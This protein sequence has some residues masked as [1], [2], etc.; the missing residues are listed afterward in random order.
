[1]TPTDSN[2]A[3]RSGGARSSPH[4]ILEEE[5]EE[6]RFE[7]GDMV[8]VNTGIAEDLSDDIMEEAV[9]VG[10]QHRS[11]SN[12]KDC[13]YLHR[14][15]PLQ[16]PRNY[17]DLNA[18]VKH[19]TTSHGKQGSNLAQCRYLASVLEEGKWWI[20]LDCG[21]HRRCS[22]LKCSLS[23]SAKGKNCKVEPEVI[24]GQVAP[25]LYNIANKNK[26]LPFV[27]VP[28]EV[29]DPLTI[30]R[31]DSRGNPD[32]YYQPFSEG[33]K[34]G[35]DYLQAIMK[36]PTRTV[37]KLNKEIAIK[38]LKI[39]TCLLE[40]VNTAVKEKNEEKER[41]FRILQ[42][43]LPKMLLARIAK[44]KHLSA[45]QRRRSAKKLQTQVI[46]DRI[47]KFNSG[48][49]GQK[50][51]FRE[52]CNPLSLAPPSGKPTDN[53]VRAMQYLKVGR[54]REAISALGSIGV[55][56]LTPEVLEALKNMHPSAT[57]VFD[58]PGQEEDGNFVVAPGNSS[59][60]Q[61]VKLDLNN[62][63]YL[64]QQL[65]SFPR[66]SAA[67]KDGFYPQFYR[68]MLKYALPTSEER[69]LTAS[70]VFHN[71]VLAGELLVDFSPWFN[72]AII[73]PLR[74]Q[75]STDPRPV[76]IGLAMRRVSSK[77]ANAAALAEAME[78]FKGHQV[79]VGTP[80][81]L[82]GVAHAL[83]QVLEAYDY[84]TVNPELQKYLLLVDFSNAFNS[85][86]RKFIFR[87]VWKCCPSISK[88]VEWC[89]RA[90]AYIFT[91]DG[92]FLCWSKSGVQQG[93]PLGPLLFSLVLQLLVDQLKLRF[94]DLD[95]NAWY[96]DDGTIVGTKQTLLLLLPI[97]VEEGAKLGLHLNREKTIVWCLHENTDMVSEVSERLIDYTAFAQWAIPCTSSAHK[98]L[99]SPFGS[100]SGC[101]LLL[102]RKVKKIECIMEGVIDLDSTQAKYYL[103]MVSGIYARYNYWL[104]TVPA[105]HM[106]NTLLELDK[107]WSK[108]VATLLPGIVI[109]DW[110]AARL[111]LP[112]SL[113]GVNLPIPS[114]VAKC[115]YVGSVIGS[116][117]VQAALLKV[118]PET[119][120]TK[121]NQL[122]ANFN[123]CLSDTAL[124]VATP[125][126][127]ES[128]APQHVCMAILGKQVINTILLKD[129]V[130][131][132]RKGLVRSCL[133]PG[134]GLVFQTAPLGDRD[135]NF[136]LNNREFDVIFRSYLGI[137]RRD[138]VVACPLKCRSMLDPQGIHA[139]I[140]NSTQ[141]AS[142]IH[143]AVRDQI[144]IE[145]RNAGLKVYKE[146]QYL[147]NDSGDKPADIFFP[148]GP[149]GV[150]VALD[151][152]KACPLSGNGIVDDH[153]VERVI[154][155]KENYKNSKYLARC[156]EV[157]I[158]FS[159]LVFLS[160][161]GFSNTMN[162][163]LDFIAKAYCTRYN[164]LWSPIAAS[165]RMRIAMV[166]ARFRAHAILAR[167]A[168]LL[169]ADHTKGEW[170][171][172]P[173]KMVKVFN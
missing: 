73:I 81:G 93:D 5:K 131:S 69:Y 36:S 63:E 84:F 62:T 90:S 23:R 154:V 126:L 146:T 148:A 162:M 58:P 49:E 56:E 129:E 10:G 152:V 67:G 39:E 149:Y 2:P 85:V 111:S 4:P 22:L 104:R 92:E 137:S 66:N 76:A 113:S 16:S 87:Q 28:E 124:H 53:K 100:K 83:Q 32:E 46:L 88:Y 30:G 143:N 51:L 132:F 79:G 166:V 55:H 141:G 27:L 167:E 41:N 169:S 31:E 1:M 61:P 98:T 50:T 147:L 142:M 7:E 107:L 133:F 144:L 44:G 70:S 95:L 114:K 158:Q 64:K 77:I 164:H 94:P 91:M 45:V 172:L 112:F 15:K 139:E 34:D 157:G 151:L 99:G 6:G 105:S 80:N 128:K 78:Y 82:D 89:Y 155:E 21:V 57:T 96:L 109:D 171:V 74:K 20:C 97:L 108:V 101:D 47:K 134:S 18:L 123:S 130:G 13:M 72:S 156:A 37:P 110:L 43:G 3:R 68:D 168:E 103:F 26:Q 25:G 60:I 35:V 8:G 153:F 116:V 159:P 11:G 14:H 48:V 71:Q 117:P 120:Y 150:P 86:E 12:C 121:Y 65:L 9:G 122:V 165:L 40:I 127:I 52:A 59:N 170:I 42:M 138:A 118:S 75:H 19:Y 119:L 102:L 163:Y 173:D 17:K 106:E 136:F 24:N 160:Q 161:G 54:P 145:C 125:T 140:C 135:F 38:Y 33:V 29:V 115:A